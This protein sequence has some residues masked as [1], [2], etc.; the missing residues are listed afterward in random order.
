MFI[1]SYEPVYQNKMKQ[2]KMKNKTKTELGMV[3]HDCNPS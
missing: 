3:E 2:T 1:S